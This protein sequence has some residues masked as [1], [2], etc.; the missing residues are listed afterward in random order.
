MEKA[1]NRRGHRG[2]RG[3][4]GSSL[5]EGRCPHPLPVVKRLVT[6]ENRKYG[7]KWPRPKGLRPEDFFSPA[8]HPLIWKSSLTQRAQRK[9]RA[10]RTAWC[11]PRDDGLRACGG[12][13]PRPTGCSPALRSPL[14]RAEQRAF[15]PALCIKATCCTKNGKWQRKWR[16]GGTYESGFHSFCNR[17]PSF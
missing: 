1:L 15:G 13:P 9:P 8:L 4:H 17:T 11:F 5:T 12:R 7:R 3:R 16:S 6:G 10:R 14:R 2:R